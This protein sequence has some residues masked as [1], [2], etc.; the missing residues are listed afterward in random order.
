M[1]IENSVGTLIVCIVVIVIGGW[2]LNL[3]CDGKDKK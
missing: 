1:I 3:D 2:L